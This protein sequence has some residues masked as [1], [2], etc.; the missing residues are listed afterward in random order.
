MASTGRSTFVSIEDSYHGNSLG[1]M[2]VGA[3]EYQEDLPTCCAAA[4]R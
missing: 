2:S 4:S 3:S 1:T